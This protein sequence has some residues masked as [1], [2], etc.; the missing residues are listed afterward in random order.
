MNAMNSAHQDIF[1]EGGAFHEQF[2]HGRAFGKIIV[3][4]GSLHFETQESV[5]DIPL[6][7]ILIKAGG[8]NDGTIFF[9]HPS[10]PGWTLFAGD[11]AILKDANLLSYSDIAR[12]IDRIQEVKTQ[13]NKVIA[14]FVVFCLIC[15]YGLFQLKEPLVTATAKQIPAVWEQKLGD[16]AMSQLKAGTRFVEAPGALEILKQITTPLLSR[17]PEKRNTFRI[18]IAEDSAINAFALPGG[19]IVLNTGL[20]LSAESAEDI[21][22]VLA[23]EAAHVTLQ[24]GLRQLIGSAGIYALAQAFFGDATGL[25]AVMVEN[26][27]FLLTRKYSRDYE[28]DADDTGWRYLVNAGINPRGMTDFFTKLLEKEQESL[29]SRVGDALNFLSTHPATRER[30]A[31]LQDKEK[32]LDRHSGYMSFHPNFQKLQD[33]LRKHVQKEISH[34]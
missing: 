8:A 26:G 27:A 19:H 12:Q 13:S 1:Y 11:H 4:A 16:A 34:E 20:I 15:I 5:T 7:G 9:M 22:G 29:P 17:I 28:R 33:M 31:R 30:I 10:S 24:H 3:T 32:T 2:S 18:H 21:L 23:H 14:A 6:Q 25:M